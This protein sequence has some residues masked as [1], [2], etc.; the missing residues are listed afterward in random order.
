[1]INIQHPHTFQNPHIFTNPTHTLTHT[2]LQTTP[3]H[4]PTHFYK[5]HSYT[6]PHT[7]QTTLTHSPIHFRIKQPLLQDTLD[8][9][10]HNTFQDS[11]YNVTLT[12]VELLS[13]P[14]LASLHFN[15]RHFA[16]ITTVHSTSLQSRHFTSLHLLALIPHL[17]T[18]ACEY[19]LYPFSKRI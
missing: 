8:L 6:H 1:M 19:L 15:Q 4:S 14:S 2:F 3:I 10:C 9:K 17:K 18:L 7:L 12:L 5:L 13:P 16:Q 11:Q